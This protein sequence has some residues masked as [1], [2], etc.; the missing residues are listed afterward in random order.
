MDAH[1][2]E[3]YE[4]YIFICQRS[5]SFQKKCSMFT[6]LM[7]GEPWAWPVVGITVAAL[8]VLAKNDYK[9]T[10]GIVCRAHIVDRIATARAIFENREKPMQQTELLELLS[11]SDKTVISTR[12]ENKTNGK[13]PEFI[14]IDM[15]RGL[16]Q[17]RLIAWK[18]G[19][20]EC[21]YLRGL[22]EDFK[23]GKVAPVSV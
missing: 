6:A 1:D 7:A 12:S 9:Y 16:F 23:N 22:H 4:T 13:L 18:H 3:F 17:S 2:P 14:P 5:F 20:A 11:K 19:P 8:E 15:K 21:D 10:K